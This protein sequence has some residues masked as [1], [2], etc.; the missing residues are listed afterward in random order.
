ML[1]QGS[2]FALGESAMSRN[3]GL[4]SDTHIPEAGASIW[5]IKDDGIEPFDRD[6]VSAENEAA[7]PQS[8]DIDSNPLRDAY[9]GDTHIHTVLSFDAYLMGTRRTPEEAYAFAKGEVI[10]HAAGR[11]MQ[12]HQPLDFLAVSDHAVYPGM[13][14][15]L[16]DED[17]V[18]GDHAL[19]PAVRGATAAFQTMIGHVRERMGDPGLEDDLD[20][21]RRVRGGSTPSDFAAIDGR[22]SLFMNSSG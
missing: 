6:A 5:L 11:M 15:E 22:S 12:L 10:Q 17:S 20:T 9:F 7:T 16:A 8:P 2:R 3:I 4:I 1:A 13:M 19:S 14:R 18:N 21:A